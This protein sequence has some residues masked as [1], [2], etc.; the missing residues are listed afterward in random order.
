MTD[1]NNPLASEASSSTAPAVLA[2]GPEFEESGDPAWIAPQVATGGA[3]PVDLYIARGRWKERA[4][5]P[6]LSQRTY[7]RDDPLSLGRTGLDEAVGR[8]TRL[9]P[10]SDG[11]EAGSISTA[12][13]ACAIAATYDVLEWVHSLNEYLVQIEQ[14]Y[15]TAS[16]IDKV[17]GPF[18]EGAIGARNAAHHGLRRVVSVVWLGAPIYRVDGYRWVHTGTYTDDVTPSVRWLQKLPGPALRFDEQRRN[19]EAHLSGR[20]VRGTVLRLHDFFF[21]TVDGRPAA[22][23]NLDN[24]AYHPAPIDPRGSAQPDGSAAEHPD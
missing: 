21:Q 7:R 24:P 13:L 2:V 16:E 15:K 5:P 8:L 6:D 1:V 18:V 3:R 17:H 10:L 9:L 14:R 22:N 11:P 20:D 4:Y 19:Y 12:D 23:T